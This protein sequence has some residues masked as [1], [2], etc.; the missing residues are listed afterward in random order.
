MFSLIRKLKKR[1]AK[2]LPQVPPMWQPG[3]IRSLK[4]IKLAPPQKGGAARVVSGTTS[5]ALYG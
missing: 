5:T 1:H 2:S 4:H 3:I